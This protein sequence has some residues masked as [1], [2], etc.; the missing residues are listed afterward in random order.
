MSLVKVWTDVGKKH[1]VPLLAKIIEKDGPILTI[2]YLTE[3]KDKIWKYEEDTYDI[4]DD[5]IAEYLK[6]DDEDQLGFIKVDGGYRHLQDDNS[7]DEYVPE[8]SDSDEEESDDDID[9]D[10]DGEDE[11]EDIEDEFDSDEEEEESD[12]ENYIE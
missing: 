2:Q 5:S 9:D 1:P 4:E 3:G 7:D 11:E 12:E 8:E 10:S 6:T